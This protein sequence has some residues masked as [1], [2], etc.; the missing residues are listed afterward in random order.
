MGDYREAYVARFKL[1][2][3]TRTRVERLS[4]DE[5]GFVLETSRASSRPIR[6]S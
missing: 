5:G 1:P 6:W 2:V 3:Q 4:R